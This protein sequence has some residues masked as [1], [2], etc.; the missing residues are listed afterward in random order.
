MDATARE[1]SAAVA[2][3]ENVWS[4]RRDAG[5]KLF[6][7]DPESDGGKRARSPRRARHKR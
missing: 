6:G 5:A 2:D 4:W 1:T 3:G 7:D